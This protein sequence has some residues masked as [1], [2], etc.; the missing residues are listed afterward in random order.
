MS[1]I[2]K[3]NQQI[4]F[5]WTGF[6]RRQVSMAE[7]CGFETI[8]LPV[9]RSAGKLK[10]IL[11]YLCHGW[12]TFATLVQSRPSVVWIQVPQ[13]PLMWVAIFY[14]SLFHRDVV[15]IADCHNSMFRPPWSRMFFG[16]SMLSRC[17]MVL[18]HNN[19][20]TEIAAQLGVDRSR[21][22]VV[23]D[24]PAHFPRVGHFRE[25]DGIP[26]PWF[27]FPA[28]FAEDEPIA[29][30]LDAAGMAPEIS[31]LITGNV[32]K[33]AIS[34]LV[35]IAPAN[36]RFLGYLSRE[37]F[38]ALVL[39]CDAIIAFTR[40]DGIQLSVCG[41]A[42]GAAKPMLISDTRILRKLF[43]IGTVFVDS[44]DPAAI[45]DG[46]RTVLSRYDELAREIQDFRQILTF[47]WITERGRPMLEKIRVLTG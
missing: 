19:A 21:L 39:D 33:S 13:V 32:Y 44:S 31:V 25:A 1:S 18:T 35:D 10:K 30:L 45:S 16:I 34:K 47:R 28:S 7:Y 42:V 26:R 17:N 22:M 6:Q 41:E 3:H 12:R 46:F 29:E 40:F 27:V 43:P 24:P 14:R 8:F 15:V 23:E 11:T 9:E 5:A 2:P 37:D 20:V 36:V 38:E 4:Y